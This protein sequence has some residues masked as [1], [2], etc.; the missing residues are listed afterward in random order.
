MAFL[1]TNNGSWILIKQILQAYNDLNE[2]NAINKLHRL[3]IFKKV[4]NSLLN[5]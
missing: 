3:T 5:S 2:F 4:S 1:R